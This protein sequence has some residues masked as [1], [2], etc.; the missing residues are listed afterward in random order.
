MIDRLRKLLAIAAT[1]D[2]GI[3]GDCMLDCYVEVEETRTNPE[4]DT[5]VFRVDNLNQVFYPGGAANTERQLFFVCDETTL[6][7]SGINC[8]SKTRYVK[9]GHVLLRIDDEKPFPVIC[10]DD[11]SIEKCH[12]WV[13]SDYHKGTI[14]EQDLLNL[15]QKNKIIVW[16]TKKPFNTRPIGNPK[17]VIKMNA[18]DSMKSTG[19]NTP[20]LAAWSVASLTGLRTIITRGPLPPLVF[21]PGMYYD[22]GNEETRIDHMAIKIPQLSSLPNPF[23]SSGAGDA[24]SG[25]LALFMA[26]DEKFDFFGLEEAATFA[27]IAASAAGS[28]GIFRSP[29][30]RCEI[31]G[32]LDPKERKLPGEELEKWIKHRVTGPLVVTNGCFDMIHPGHVHLLNRCRQLG[33]KV[34]VLVNTDESVRVIKGSGKPHMDLVG[35]MEM[36]AALDSVDAIIPFDGSATVAIKSIHDMLGRKV[37]YLVKGADNNETPPG[38]EYAE[39]VEL[40]PIYGEH[41]SDIAKRITSLSL[42][43]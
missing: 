20:S 28:T 1:R 43:S 11:D 40:V 24:F 2:I 31:L 8:I 14:Q 39:K 16:D 34:L 22:S 23:E 32:M 10:P 42:R 30:L 7:G 26:C 13:V 29:V 18:P 17:F 35:R 6:V 33:G 38:Y 41:S 21:Y 12:A 9:N 4:A 37:D 27:H 5:P 36:L 3:W 15:A 25:F 19:S